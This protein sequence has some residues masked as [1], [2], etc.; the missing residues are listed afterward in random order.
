EQRLVRVLAVDVDEQRADVLQ[1]RERNRPVVHERARAAFLA[2]D[3]PERAAVLVF[4]AELLEPRERGMA[5]RALEQH[6]DLGALG[7]VADDA[8]V[9]AIAEHEAERV[10]E[11]RLARARLA[12]HDAHAVAE[13]E[14]DLVDDGEALDADE[15]QHRPAVTAS[16]ANGRT[17]SRCP[18]SASSEAARSSCSPS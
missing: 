12:G 17:G 8:R 5:R 10:D 6:A 14:L 2:D 15:A 4:E 11:N 9:R 7:A 18:S 3:P 16:A 1:V 13:L